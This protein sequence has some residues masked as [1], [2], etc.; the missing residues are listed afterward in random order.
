MIYTEENK[1]IYGGEYYI[2]CKKRCKLYGEN[3]ARKITFYLD[4]KYIFMH[5]K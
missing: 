5:C 2:Y 3:K 4:I 1:G